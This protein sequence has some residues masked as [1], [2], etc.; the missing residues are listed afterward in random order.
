MHC[1]L[2][3]LIHA[4]EVAIAVLQ[5]S[6]ALTEIDPAIMAPHLRGVWLTM[7][8]LIQHDVRDVV[9][10]QPYFIAGGCLYTRDVQ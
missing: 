5:A 7:A 4:S 2:H 9:Q 6:I 3:G 1:R 8:Q 10:Q